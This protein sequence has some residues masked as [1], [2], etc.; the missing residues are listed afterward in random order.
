MF[1]CFVLTG[2]NIRKDTVRLDNKPR[3]CTYRVKN[4]TVMKKCN[5]GVHA[6][7]KCLVKIEGN[8]NSSLKKSYVNNYR[9][10]K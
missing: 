2:R 5:D 6:K 10:Y 1:G 4:K 8:G 9:R 3:F 7:D